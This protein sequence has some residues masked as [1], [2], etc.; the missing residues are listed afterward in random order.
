MIVA[1]HGSSPDGALGK[2]LE[3]KVN[4]DKACN[5]LN[6]PNRGSLECTS[7]PTGSTSIH[8]VEQFQMALDVGF[9][10]VP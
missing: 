8:R 9:V 10:K 3:V 2:F 5:R 6:S 7:D 1:E 4:Q